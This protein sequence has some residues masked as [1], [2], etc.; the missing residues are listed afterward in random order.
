MA[1][2]AIEAV[3]AR[4]RSVFGSWG[5][6]TAVE[7]MRRDVE[8]LFGP[9][10][11]K[12][13]SERVEAGGVP[14]EWVT[15]AGANPDRVLLYFH[16][17]GYSVGSVRSHWDLIA[18]LSA[19]TGCRVLALDYR[20]APENLFP[21][22]IEDATAAYGWLLAE[23]TVPGHIALAGDSAGGGIC[24]ATLV[25]LRDAGTALP[26]AAVLL[27]PW[28]DL[29]ARGA[30]YETRA[31]LDPMVQRQLSLALA[32]AYLGAE[33]DR[34]HPLAS[35]LYAD[36]A[37]LP[38]LLIQVGDHE[39]LLDDATSFAAKARAAGVDVTLEVW[40]E[41][42]HDFQLFAAELPD[43]QRAIEGIGSFIRERWR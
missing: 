1:S 41:M 18:R 40:D 6:V 15:A 30:S 34:R 9:K 42:I 36:L 31:E 14:A 25:A 17:G 39:T 5:E 13:D 32:A 23:G 8:D 19:A 35:P 43:A 7:Q 38:P 21:A 33:G 26:A 10:D 12:A 3:K 20:R 29:E 22:P 2:P 27:S 37:G 11:A 4:I 28:V 16:G 24:A